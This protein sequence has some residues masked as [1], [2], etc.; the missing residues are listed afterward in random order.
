[1]VIE[2]GA[3]YRTKAAVWTVEHRSP[4][5]MLFV[6]RDDGRTTTF[7]ERDFASWIVERIA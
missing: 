1:M 2:E 7:G 6:R 4:S 3:T 5:G